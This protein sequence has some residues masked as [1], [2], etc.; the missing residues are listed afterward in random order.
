MNLKQW[1]CMACLAIFI[2]KTSASGVVIPVDIHAPSTGSLSLAILDTNGLMVRNLL[3]AQPVPAGSLR[4][5][6]D[7]TTDMG[8]PVAPGEYQTRAVLFTNPP[9]LSYVMKVGTSGNPPWRLRDQTGDWGGDL[10][11][12]TAICA[13]SN[14]LLMLWSAVENNDLSG[15]QRMDTNGNILKRYVS[16]YP[17]DGRHSAAMDETNWFLGFSNPYAQ[18][19]ELAVYSIG[20]TNGRILATLPTPPHVML[21]GRFEK[22]W[23]SWFSGLAITSNRIYAAVEPDDRLFI[24]DR[25]SGAILEEHTVPSPRG[26]IIRGDRLLVV[27]SNQVLSLHLDGTFDSTVVPSGILEEPN[28]IGVDA[29]GNIYVGDSGAL[30][31]DPEAASSI[32]PR[33]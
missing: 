2:A 28:A 14:S 25:A 20:Q 26:I 1:A 32:A 16:F 7:G 3:Y 13:N 17:Y 23:Q 18:R 15:I 29:S 24:L 8:V 22:R 12:P 19:L 30:R 21:S 27:S 11:G 9:S 33:A 31:F 4:F 6:W 10:G 5:F